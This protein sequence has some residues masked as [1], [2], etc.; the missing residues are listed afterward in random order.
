MNRK[1]IMRKGLEILLISLLLG[2]AKMSRAEV[3]PVVDYAKYQYFNG[4]EKGDD[5]YLG[6]IHLNNDS[7]ELW[8]EP[9]KTEENVGVGGIKKAW[10]KLTSQKPR[11]YK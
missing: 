6:K 1:S 5:Y 11:L 9:V 2:A 3:I 7:K 4:Q 8:F 10:H